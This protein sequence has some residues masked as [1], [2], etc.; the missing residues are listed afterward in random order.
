MEARTT[1]LP[2]SRGHLPPHLFLPHL[3]PSS[4]LPPPPTHSTHQ[5]TST[6]STHAHRNSPLASLL[7]CLFCPVTSLSSCSR[8]VVVSF[9]VSLLRL[10]TC[11]PRLLVALSLVLLF[12]PFF[13][14][15]LLAPQLLALWSS[16]LAF[17]CF[18]LLLLVLVFSPC[19]SSKILTSGTQTQAQTI[20]G[21]RRGR[22][23]AGH[24]RT[25]ARN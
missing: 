12:L 1:H 25:D 16:P 23:G 6:P 24:G 11:S 5:P 22:V 10:C 3:P 8:V 17:S 21:G 14:L 2:K 4:P 20:L 18:S 7:P 15:S 9:E 19:F 13:S